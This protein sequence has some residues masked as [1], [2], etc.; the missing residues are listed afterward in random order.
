MEAK[1]VEAEEKKRREEREFEEKKVE[2]EERKRR[3]EREF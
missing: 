2:A 1:R 3:E